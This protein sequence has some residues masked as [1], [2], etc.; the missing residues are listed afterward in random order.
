MT[1]EYNRY[2]PYRKTKQ[3]WYLDHYEP[4]P[5]RQADDD[6][7]ITLTAKYNEDPAKLAYEEYGNER[8]W[9]VFSLANMDILI[10]PIYDFTTGTTV[11]VPS[12][13]RIEK[14]IGGN[15]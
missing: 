11:R 2:S 8:L 3:T 5:I 7:Y 4:K 12:K 14:L 6:K 10:D 1:I 9:Y 13:A 15:F